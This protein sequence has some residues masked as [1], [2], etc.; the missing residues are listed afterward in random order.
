MNTTE[1]FLSKV[2]RTE[3][4]WLWIGSTNFGGYG[5]YY[6]SGRAVRAHRFSYELFVGKI[7]DGLELDHLCRYK[8][9]VNPKHLEPVTHQENVIRGHL[10]K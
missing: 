2:K 3:G 5:T 7:P 10:E 9:C 8:S 6:V 1:R 4:C